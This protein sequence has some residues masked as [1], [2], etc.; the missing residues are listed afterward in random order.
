MSVVPILLYARGYGVPI[1]RQNME[2]TEILM[3]VVIGFW[4]YIPA[5][6]PNSNAALIGG[7]TPVDFGKSW[8]GQRILGDGKTWRGFIGGALSGVLIGILMIGIS[9][10]CGSEDHWGFGPSW[11]DNIGLLF[12][13]SFGSLIGDMMGS[14]VKRR[15]GIGRG[16]KAPLLD[17]F[18]YVVGSFLLMAI[19]YPG[20]VYSTYFEGYHIIVFVMLLLFVYASH[21]IVNII[22]YKMGVKDEP[23]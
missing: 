20:W 19:F 7:G 12:C 2:I 15:L 4:V 10:L 13:M 9:V 6:L 1:K 14:F 22:G 5:M 23:W 3:M 16:A 21:R 18:D 8:K 17:Q 11:A